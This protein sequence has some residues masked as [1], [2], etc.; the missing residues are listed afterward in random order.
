MAVWSLKRKQD[1]FGK[2]TKYKAQLCCHDGQTIKGVHYERTFSLVVEWAMV[3]L[4]LKLSLV[5]G[6]HARQIDFVLA[7][8]QDL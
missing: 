4:M 3:R 8:P 1:P 5:H 2:I 7:F 6:W